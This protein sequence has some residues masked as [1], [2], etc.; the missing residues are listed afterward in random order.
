MAKERRRRESDD[1]S[2]GAAMAH[3]HRERDSARKDAEK[4]AAK[5]L[6][7]LMGNFPFMIAAAKAGWVVKDQ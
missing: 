3:A 1:V 5:H 4:R 7:F 6:G 2:I